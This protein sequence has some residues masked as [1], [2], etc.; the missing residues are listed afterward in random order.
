MQDKGMVYIKG[1]ME[2]PVDSNSTVLSTY[3]NF[4]SI[5]F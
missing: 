5:L 2:G 1:G 3:F 4:L